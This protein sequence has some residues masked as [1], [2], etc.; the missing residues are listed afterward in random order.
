MD[1]K[2]AVYTLQE[3]DKHFIA[4]M[5]GGVGVDVLMST[6]SSAIESTRA[7]RSLLR[8]GPLGVASAS[9]EKPSRLCPIPGHES[10]ARKER[11]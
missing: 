10:H 5:R 6:G 8:R 2:K 3:Y 7:S 1:S 11:E 9:N 4:A